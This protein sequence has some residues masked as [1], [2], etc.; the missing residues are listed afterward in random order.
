[1]PPIEP[2]L[3]AFDAEEWRLADDS[4]P[5]ALALAGTVL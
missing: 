5:F 4:L 2:G 3:N 1:M